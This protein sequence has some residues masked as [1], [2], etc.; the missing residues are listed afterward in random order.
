MD[1]YHVINC[2]RDDTGEWAVTINQNIQ[3]T[4]SV[5]L[6][7]VPLWECIMYICSRAHVNVLV[8]PDC[9][10]TG[11]MQDLVSPDYDSASC[12][13]ILMSILKGKG[14]QFRLQGG[15]LLITVTV[16]A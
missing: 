15:L 4:I 12:A 5:N 8:H 10:K 11:L 9:F 14:M 3:K 6:K 16:G 13:D 2:F 1:L 7:D